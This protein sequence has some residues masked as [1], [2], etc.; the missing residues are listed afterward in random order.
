MCK[1]PGPGVRVW[2]Q[3]HDYWYL[4]GYLLPDVVQ[5]YIPFDR[6]AC[7]TGCMSFFKGTHKMGRLDHVKVGTQRTVEPQAMDE[8]LTRYEKVSMVMQPGDGLFFHANTIHGSGPNQS[9]ITRH[10]ILIDY[11]TKRNP[12]YKENSQEGYAPLDRWSD[13]AI[14]VLG[15]K[16][17][18]N[19]DGTK[20]MLC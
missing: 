17:V 5:L 16:A 11:N 6:C 1:K 14:M 20:F 19:D 7:D 9:E 8:V 18:T 15:S 12:A 4:N 3:D 2:H 10:D 13:D